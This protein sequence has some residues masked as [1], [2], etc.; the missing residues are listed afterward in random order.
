[1]LRVSKHVTVE[2]SRPSSD[3][4]DEASCP[5]GGVWLPEI[6]L[7]KGCKPGNEDDDCQENF[8]FCRPSDHTCVNKRCRMEVDN[9]ALVPLRGSGSV[10]SAEEGYSGQASTDFIGKLSRLRHI[11]KLC[12]LIL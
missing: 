3:T 10:G 7:E 12:S 2:C 11:S 1:M 6:Q 8:H 9:G 4:P 5:S